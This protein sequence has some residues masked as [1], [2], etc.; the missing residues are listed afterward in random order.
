VTLS[1]ISQWEIPKR[2]QIF[3][4]KYQKLASIAWRFAKFGKIA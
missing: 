2:S 4:P 3:A 1:I